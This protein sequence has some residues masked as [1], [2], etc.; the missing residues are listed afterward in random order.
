MW[1]YQP[2]K[3]C[4]FYMTFPRDRFKQTL[5][6]VRFATWSF[7]KLIINKLIKVVSIIK[8]LQ[9]GQCGTCWWQTMEERRK[10]TILINICLCK[11]I[12]FK[13]AIRTKNYEPYWILTITLLWLWWTNRRR[14]R[15]RLFHSKILRKE[16]YLE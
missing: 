14:C 4:S 3:S 7:V 5:K 15:R 16:H 13:F 6:Y 9:Y 11:R 8:L 12:L 10:T 1:K 2:G